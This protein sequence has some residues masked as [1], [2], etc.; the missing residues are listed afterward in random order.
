LQSS[1]ALSLIASQ[2]TLSWEVEFE[3]HTRSVGT[4]GT[5]FVS[6]HGYFNTAVVA[7][8]YFLIP[9]STAVVS[10]ACDL[11]LANLIS[12]QFK[13]SGSTAEHMWCQ[14][15]EVTSLN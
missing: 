5:L 1:A 9:A 14:D 2:T 10:G 6:G 4:T 11:T 12:L 8:G 15:L 3:V 7:A 13:R